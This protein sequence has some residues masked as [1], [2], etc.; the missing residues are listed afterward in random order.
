MVQL[1]HSILQS[2]LKPARYT[3]GEWNAVRKDWASAEC[4]FALALPDV[5]EVG[6]SNLGLAILYEILNHRTDIAAERV[7]APWID[8]EEKMREQGIPLF[9]LESRRPIRAFDF[10]GFSLQYEMIYS[11]VLNMLDLAGIPLYA[12][13][14]G[15]DMPFI[16]GGGP[17]VYNV[18][19][20]ADVTK[21][22]RASSPLTASIYPR[23][24]SRSTTR[25]GIF[26]RCVSCI[27]RRVP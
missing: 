23:S 16:V 7:Y 24:M 21:S 27:L 8:M 13:E 20:I 4:K 18:E 26:V 10:L 15:E 9:A 12:R 19:P 2:V 25:R 11:N 6:M 14:R 3:G 17:C 1:D 22:S 5:Y